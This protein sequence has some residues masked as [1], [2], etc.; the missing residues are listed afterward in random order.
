MILHWIFKGTESILGNHIIPCQKGKDSLQ[1]LRIHLNR[2]NKILPSIK[3]YRIQ[4]LE[5]YGV[6]MVTTTLESRTYDVWS[7]S[8]L[9]HCSHLNLDFCWFH[10]NIMLQSTI[11]CTKIYV[12]NKT[13]NQN[14]LYFILMKNYLSQELCE[15]QYHALF[16]V[17]KASKE[18]Y[19]LQNDCLLLKMSTTKA[20]CW[21]DIE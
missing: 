17:W 1:L 13:R 20:L 3:W 15:G 7:G 9:P 11:L 14:I 4:A 5:T 8:C 18:P 16:L 2:W 12:Y 6:F 19:Q 21:I 10:P